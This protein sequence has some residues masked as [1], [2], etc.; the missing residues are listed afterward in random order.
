MLV[1]LAIRTFWKIA[2]KPRVAAGWAEKFTELGRIKLRPMPLS[3]NM[4]KVLIG[5]NDGNSA[6]ETGVGHVARRISF[7]E[8]R[9]SRETSRC[10]HQRKRRERPNP[11]LHLISATFPSTKLR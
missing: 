11:I 8:R 7:A 4:A 2:P 3:L 6:G 1:V 9:I 5:L 10:D